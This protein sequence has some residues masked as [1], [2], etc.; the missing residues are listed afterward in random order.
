MN[1]KK[2]QLQKL[3]MTL[4][5]NKNYSVSNNNCFNHFKIMI[6]IIVKLIVVFY[7]SNISDNLYL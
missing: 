6:K 1:K 3:S 2:M 4:C 7:R 5:I